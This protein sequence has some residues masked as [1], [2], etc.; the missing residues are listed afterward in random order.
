VTYEMPE[1][2]VFGKP[3]SAQSLIKGHEQRD[4]K[5]F[6]H[7]PIAPEEEDYDKDIFTK[8][9]VETGLPTFIKLAGN[10]D[11][12]HVDWA[13]QWRRTK[14]PDY[15][16]A[17]GRP[18]EGPDGRPWLSDE[19][20]PAGTKPW[21][22][23]CWR[24]VAEAGQ[25]AA[26]SLEG[27]WKARDPQDKRKII[28]SEIHL[29]TIDPQPKGFNNFLKVGAPESL[30]QIAKGMLADYDRGDLGDAGWIPMPRDLA[31]EA[32]PAFWGDEAFAKSMIEA[33][34]W[35]KRFWPGGVGTVVKSP[36]GHEGENCPH[37]G[38]SM[39][40]GDDGSYNRCNKPWPAAKKAFL[41]GDGTVADGTTG[42]AADRVQTL[43]ATEQPRCP[44]C[45]KKNR[46]SRKHCRSCHRA[47]HISKSADAETPE[48]HARRTGAKPV[49]GSSV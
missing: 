21:A 35:P 39:E 48:P 17:K 45:G 16:I 31:L 19:L 47:L 12:G 18:Y 6:L 33:L 15:I 49:G 36:S 32:M 30:Q 26:H 34:Q 29:I 28:V 22:D 5:R 23:K 42:G 27:L 44:G 7:G 24:H 4:G 41:T 46:L 40:R 14:D 38:A 13:H 37:C 11:H 3:F 43:V 8:A 1:N 9:G 2:M 25:H 10:K 20:A